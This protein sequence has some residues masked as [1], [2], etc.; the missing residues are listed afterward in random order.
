MG[1]KIDPTAW[2]GVMEPK[3]ANCEGGLKRDIY[4]FCTHLIDSHG[5]QETPG[6]GNIRKG[7]R[8]RCR[9]TR[10][11]RFECRS[12]GPPL[13]GVKNIGAW[14]Y[15]SVERGSIASERLLTALDCNWGIS[16]QR[17]HICRGRKER[18]GS[19]GGTQIPRNWALD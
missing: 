9:S 1:S 11:S 19:A 12:G 18:R 14:R 15:M 13:V 10:K 16:P 4:T 7:T 17:I 5:T 8:P 2:G 6:I 3:N